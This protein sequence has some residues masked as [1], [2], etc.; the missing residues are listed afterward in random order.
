MPEN[1]SASL[2]AAQMALRLKSSRSAA[3]FSSASEVARR[4]GWNASTYRAHEN[5]Q[6]P[7]KLADAR[8]Y[9]EA[10]H[11]SAVWLLTGIE[12]PVEKTGRRNIFDGK[13]IEV[14]SGPDKVII[15]FRGKIASGVWMEQKL[16]QKAG[17]DTAQKIAPIDPR[18]SA[19]RQFDFLISDDHIDAVAP[20]GFFVRCVDID[21]YSTSLSDGDFVVIERHGH[22][23]LV[24]V[25]GKAVEKNGDGFILKNATNNEDLKNNIIH[26]EPKV[27]ADNIK[28]IGKILWAYK[29]VEPA[30]E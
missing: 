15:S 24:E 2:D 4:F 7:F 16:L 5:G 14:Q 22:E 12:S 29:P 21:D 9:A 11:V 13:Q 18:Y 19:E 20:V 8:K 23:G 27:H 17:R 30:F 25:T 6:N 10:F 28:I 26:Y 1:S 3:G